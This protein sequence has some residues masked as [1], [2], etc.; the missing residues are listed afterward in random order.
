MIASVHL[1]DVGLPAALKLTR[2]KL[3]GVDGLRYSAFTIAAPL[4]GHVLPRP[5]LGR[6]G[7]IATWEDDRAVENFLAGH[8]VAE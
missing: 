2:A 8:P 6:I 1:A 5:N 7:L 3:A 4:G